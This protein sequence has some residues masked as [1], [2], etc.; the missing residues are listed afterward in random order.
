MSVLRKI[1]MYRWGKKRGGCQFPNKR[2]KKKR[3]NPAAPEEKGDDK[4]D[5]VVYSSRYMKS[6]DKNRNETPNI[7]RD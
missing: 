4:E 7:K 6:C 5:I 3:A 2:E 1:C